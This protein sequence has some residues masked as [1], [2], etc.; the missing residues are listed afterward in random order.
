MT[1]TMMVRDDDRALHGSCCMPDTV[2][3]D[4]R[5][6][7]HGQP[8]PRAGR[9]DTATVPLL[10]RSFWFREIPNKTP[11]GLVS[12]ELGRLTS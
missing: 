5:L 12:M 7:T 8:R 6:R 11:T 4:R 9:H 3:Y 10:P 2:L 1:M